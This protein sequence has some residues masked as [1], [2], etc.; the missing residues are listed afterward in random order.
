MT[1]TPPQ[2]WRGRE[3]DNMNLKEAR[4]ALREAILIAANERNNHILFLQK[5]LGTIEDSIKTLEETL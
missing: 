5:V 2:V 3:I 1:P 4:Q